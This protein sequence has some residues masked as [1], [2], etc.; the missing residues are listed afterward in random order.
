VGRRSLTLPQAAWGSEPWPLMR[1]GRH[2]HTWI[3]TS[4][5]HLSITSTF[6]HQNNL[7]SCGLLNK[8]P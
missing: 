2:Q 8:I 1:V 3:P 7:S 6:F 5:T 4:L